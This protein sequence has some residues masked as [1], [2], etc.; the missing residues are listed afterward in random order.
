MSVPSPAISHLLPTYRPPHLPPCPA[1]LPTHIHARPQVFTAVLMH[2]TRDQLPFTLFQDS[3]VPA[4]TWGKD[5]G[6]RAGGAALLSCYMCS[7]A[8]GACALRAQG[9]DTEGKDSG[10]RYF[11]PG[12]GWGGGAERSR[13]CRAQRVCTQKKH[14]HWARA[15]GARTR[16]GVGLLLLPSDWVLWVMA[17]SRGSMR[18]KGRV[19]SRGGGSIH[20]R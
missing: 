19:Q 17:Q 12:R 10:G 5:S 11:T 8:Q 9:T 13:L 14:G 3:K 20:A 18:S 7:R 4:D 2:Y 1:L 6:G 16:V 15:P